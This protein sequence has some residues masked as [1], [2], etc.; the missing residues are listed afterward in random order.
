MNSC[1]CVRICASV[2]LCAYLSVCLFFKGKVFSYVRF[3]VSV[4][5]CAHLSVFLFLWECSSR[6]Y[7]CTYLC[8]GALPS[9]PLFLL[10]LLLPCF[11]RDV[12]NVRTYLCLRA[13]LHPPV[14]VFV[15]SFAY[16]E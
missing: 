5:L 3:Y 6:V 12:L 9:L 2:S 7:V 4:S 16:A 10:L 1:V 15:C 11:M 8:L 14:C 13:L